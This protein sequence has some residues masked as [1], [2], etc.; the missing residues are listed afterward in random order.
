MKDDNVEPRVHRG[1]SLLSMAIVL[2]IVLI[3][4][5]IGLSNYS[6]FMEKQTWSVTATH[7]D[8]VSQSAR[9]YIKDNYNTLLTQVKSG[10]TVTLSGQNLLDKGYLPNGFSVAN[11][12]AQ[13]Y[14]LTVA[15][16]PS[17]TDKLV[18]F[19][20]TT[21]GDQLTYEA[22][23]YISQN[24]NGLGGYVYPANVAVGANGGWQVNLTTFGLTAQTGHLV[25]YL[26]SDVLGTD[27]EES[28]R[29]YRYSVNGRPDLNAMHTSIDMGA[30]N[31]NNVGVLNGVTGNFGGNVG[32]ANVNTS[33]S[34][35]ANG[36][37][38]ANGDVSAGNAITANSDIRSNNGWIITRNDKGWL[39]ESHG[40]GFTMTDNDWVRSVND[41]GIYTGGQLRGGSV[42]ADGRM[43]VGEY[44]QLDGTAT[45]G[46]GCSPN[47]LVGRT[48]EGVL[49]YCKN[50]VWTSSNSGNLYI[51][52]LGSQ[53][54]GSHSFCALMKVNLQAHSGDTSD[55]GTCQVTRDASGIWALLD[56]SNK[57]GKGCQAVCF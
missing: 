49:L 38:S 17:Q 37:V 13:T 9:L 18:A 4:T 42:R 26:S 23:R 16:N 12:D 41:K 54:L 40:G 27:A 19:V 30:N 47:G 14:I 50:G 43:S 1:I 51:S 8:T 31:L 24:V 33:G 55:V 20:L 45:E 15:R 57:N 36:N 34:V 21:G 11:N 7:L 29:L 32:A 10:S 48:G 53:S 2:A 3:A 52:G 5:P 35:A 56:Q 44:L 46:A 22:Q 28:D 25:S 6:K 39:N